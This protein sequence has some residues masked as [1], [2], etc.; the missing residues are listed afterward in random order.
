MNLGLREIALKKSYKVYTRPFELNI[1]G[2]RSSDS[3]PQTFDDKIV[4]FWK[5]NSG[6]WNERVY[7]AT[8]DPSTYEM[9]NPSFAA[10]Q[11][12]GVPIMQQGQ[13]EGLFRLSIG[14][15]RLGI[16]ELVQVKNAKYFRDYNRDAFLDFNNGRETTENNGTNIHVGANYGQTSINVGAWGAGCQVIASWADMAEFVA[17]CKKHI[18]LYGNSFTYTLVDYRVINRSR[19]RQATYVAVAALFLGVGGYFGYEYWKKLE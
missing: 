12:N 4:V 8:T 11:L 5:D 18:S 17:M 1:W 15:K 7:K 13:Y 19:W 10:A 16:E 14:S 9:G 6:V 3:T 2:I